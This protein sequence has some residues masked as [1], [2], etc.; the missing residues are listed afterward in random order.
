MSLRENKI[1]TLPHTIGHLINLTTLDLGFNHLEHLPE[2]IGNC[3]Q[4]TTLDL[5][6]NELIELPDTIGNLKLLTR[7]GIKYKKVL[8][9]KELRR[10][11]FFLSNKLSWLKKFIK[12][13]SYYPITSFII[14]VVSDID[15]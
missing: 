10:L 8:K 14:F 4:L 2:T 11:N 5:Q 9:F 12:R 15:F 7:L 3:T 13:N 1:K 6:H